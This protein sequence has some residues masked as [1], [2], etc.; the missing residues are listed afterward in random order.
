[1]S[2][3]NNNQTKYVELKND[4]SNYK[5]WSRYI[6]S[7]VMLTGSHFALPIL[8]GKCFKPSKKGKSIKP[9]MK[10]KHSE[11]STASSDDDDDECTSK[12]WNKVNTKAKGL[13][14]NSLDHMVSRLFSEDKSAFE[15]W[16]FFENEFHKQDFQEQEVAKIEWEAL[17]LPTFTKYATYKANFELKRQKANEAGNIFSELQVCRQF[18]KGITCREMLPI[19]AQ[20]S[21]EAEIYDRS[22]Q[23][24]I[25]NAIT[26]KILERET[27]AYVMRLMDALPTTLIAK[28]SEKKT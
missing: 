10:E 14:L 7:S 2:T 4:G 13:M 19:M 26:Y 23:K 27:H 9:D 6:K 21:I 17:R 11:D 18:Y 22:T 12:E 16:K 5:R 15:N 25:A 3:E 1:M 8:T 28:L 24:S 20:F